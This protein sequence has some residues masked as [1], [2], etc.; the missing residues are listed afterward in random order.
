MKSRELDR[1]SILIAFSIHFN[2]YNQLQNVILIVL[3]Q[4]SCGPS[5]VGHYFSEALF[6]ITQ[7][8]RRPIMLD[9]VLRRHCIHRW[10][11]NSPPSSQRCARP[12]AVGL[13]RRRRLVA[14]P[15]TQL[16]PLWAAAGRAR[17]RA[18]A[19]ARAAGQAAA[20]PCIP[21]GGRW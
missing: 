18:C 20:E 3:A 1:G 14:G 5:T 19:R 10:P 17:S 4:G 21:C 15:A 9:Y 2:G 11:R 8:S 6:F 16:H 12:P 7:G 13:A